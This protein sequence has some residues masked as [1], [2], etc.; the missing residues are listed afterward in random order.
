MF[1]R[2]ASLFPPAAGIAHTPTWQSSCPCSHQTLPQD[3]DDF[4]DVMA[5]HGKQAEL[6]SCML[7]VSSFNHDTVGPPRAPLNLVS[8]SGLSGNSAATPCEVVK[9][10]V[11][12]LLMDTLSSVLLQGD[13]L[14]RSD[15]CDVWEAIA[16]MVPELMQERNCG[17]RPGPRHDLDFCEQQLF[18]QH[19]LDNMGWRAIICCVWRMGSTLYR[20][21]VEA[22]YYVFMRFAPGALL[23]NLQ[24]SIQEC[25]EQRELCME[26]QQ[27]TNKMIEE[28]ANQRKES[29]EKIEDITKISM[30][31]ISIANDNKEQSHELDHKIE[32]HKRETWG[33]INDLLSKNA[34]L[35]ET[36]KVR[37]AEI[38]LFHRETWCKINDLTN[39]NQIIVQTIKIRDATIL[40]MEA[41]L[42]LERENSSKLDCLL[43]STRISAIQDINT[44]QKIAQGQAKMANRNKDKLNKQI[45]A[46]AVL[47]DQLSTARLACTGVVDRECVVCFQSQQEWVMLRP[48]GHVCVCRGCAVGVA[49]CP[50]CR[51]LVSGTIDAFV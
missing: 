43:E 11:D 27:E 30:E 36:R 44:A 21:R 23:D 24:K 13:D 15:M 17:N 31:F 22:L 26:Q 49:N 10:L 2:W 20:A 39:N 50:L 41:Q 6:K 4:E 45:L 9:S 12:T 16:R 25:V 29:Q 34:T 7:V 18:V 37:D 19:L 32:V 1:E 38:E 28:L 40:S 14:L 48:C 5:G 47:S 42:K 3:D 46:N 51:V 8:L 33:K 35:V